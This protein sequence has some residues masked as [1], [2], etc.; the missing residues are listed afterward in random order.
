MYSAV[1]FTWFG[2][3][4]AGV[5][6]ARSSL[7]VPEAPRTAMSRRL[8]FRVTV[9]VT[10]GALPWGREF[11]GANSLL[12]Y[13]ICQCHQRFQQALWEGV[14]WHH[15]VLAVAAEGALAGPRVLPP[16]HMLLRLSASLPSSPSSL[17]P[18]EVRS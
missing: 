4:A 15:V 18:N 1:T 3:V 9:R 8:G 12:W 10:A 17:L 2:E 16:P 13:L 14:L 6:G 5:M 11:M 7:M